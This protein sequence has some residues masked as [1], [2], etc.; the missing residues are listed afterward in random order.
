MP[1]AT[2]VRVA[3]FATESEEEFQAKI[4]KAA[5]LLGWKVHAER[6]SLS[7]SGRFLT[8]VQGHIGFPDL[9]LARD[10][11]LAMWELKSQKGRVRPEQ[12]E[13]IDVLSGISNIDVR[14]LRPTDWDW[15]ERF[16][17]TAP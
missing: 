1:S 5:K 13:W 15:I 7:K 14:V 2:E 17:R 11:T 4:V 12:R 6:T 3:Y 16:L 10:R 9:V 8:A